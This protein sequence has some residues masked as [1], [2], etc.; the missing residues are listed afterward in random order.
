[1]PRN[2]N[3]RGRA[4]SWYKGKRIYH[5][6]WG[7]PEADKAYK[8]FIAALLESPTPRFGNDASDVL[9]S[10]LADGFVE[11]IEAQNMHKD[12]VRHYKTVIGY[13][14]ELYGELSVNE[15]SP[16]KLKV[17]RNQMVK[18]GTISRPMINRYVS[19]IRSVFSWGVE[20]EIVNQ[21]VVNALREVKELRRGEQG[22]FDN[23]PRKA[24]LQ[25]VVERTLPFL[26]PML[27][28]MVMV[29]LATAMR[30]SEVF[31]MTV[32]NIDRTREHEKG[33]WYYVLESHKT[34][35][36]IGQKEIPL[37]KPEQ[38]ALLPYLQGKKPT[39]AVFS[40]R[41]AMEE[42]NAEKRA[43]RKTKIT[44]SQAERNRQRAAKPRRYNELYD[45]NSFRKAIEYGIKKG[46]T[47]GVK[48]PHW[49]PTS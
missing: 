20:E 48:I 24:V 18:V 23:P 26:P 29:L 9:I 37:G 38:E 39:E 28:A 6:A 15:F 5:G 14:A 21:S 42:R 32:G 12:D 3:D 2:C 1:M 10:E 45:E 35:D 40:P 31:R 41:T 47:A 25:D 11:H 13:L 30:P 8:R 46:N 16:K 36:Y 27:R 22:T 4:F 44:P 19:K 7:T 33:L 43:N 34:E 17:V 49:T